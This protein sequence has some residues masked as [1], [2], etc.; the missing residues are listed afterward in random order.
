MNTMHTTN[1]WIV[2]ASRPWWIFGSISVLNFVSFKVLFA[3]EDRFEAIA[4]VP[5]FDTQTDLT[6]AAL[7]QQLPR[8]T[9]AAR[10]AYAWFAVFDWVFPF[11]A[12]LFLAVLWAWLLRT[13]TF[14][15]AQRLLR[16]NMPVWVF[17]VTL[18]DWLENISLLVIIYGG[19]RSSFVVQ[20]ALVW[21]RL[22]LTGLTASAAITVL[23]VALALVGLL[24][25]VWR[26]HMTD[27]KTS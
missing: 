6:P 15:I 24:Q 13:N 4:H 3:L 12:S 2:A 23:L 1:T 7:L 20:A 16:W 22:K 8:Y 11:V 18:F 27:I 5:T 25:R 10:T 26:A 19:V 14:S 9:G 17:A 21:K